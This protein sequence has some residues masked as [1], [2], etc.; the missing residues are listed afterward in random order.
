MAK[1]LWTTTWEKQST[2]VGQIPS[3]ILIGIRRKASQI[4]DPGG[5]QSFPDHWIE[6]S[7]PDWYTHMIDFVIPSRRNPSHFI[8]QNPLPKVI[9]FPNF[10][11]PNQIP[12]FQHNCITQ[13]ESYIAGLILHRASRPGCS[14]VILE[15]WCGPAR[16]SNGTASLLSWRSGLWNCWGNNGMHHFL[17]IV[18]TTTITTRRRVAKGVDTD[19]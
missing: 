9:G 11:H 14:M 6:Q 17:S 18:L 7:N 15:P 8:G 4:P 13:L 10:P 3:Q 19:S 5:V 16:S 1:S 2:F 12:K